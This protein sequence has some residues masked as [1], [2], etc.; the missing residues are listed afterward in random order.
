MLTS[1]D[2]RLD[3]PESR[4]VMIEPRLE[5]RHPFAGLLELLECALEL[6]LETSDPLLQFHRLR[7]VDLVGAR[8]WGRSAVATQTVQCVM[9]CKESVSAC[10][11]QQRQSWPNC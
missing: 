4:G 8:A 3:L 7:H 6:Q 1:S 11:D 10:H 2:D 5:R 9:Q